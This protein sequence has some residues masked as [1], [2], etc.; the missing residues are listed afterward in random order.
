MEKAQK[1]SQPVTLFASPM[2][3]E[4]YSFLGFES[5]GNISV[6]VKGEDEKLS[7]AVMVY[8][9]H[10]CTHRSDL[11]SAPSAQHQ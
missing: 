6:Q 4:L 1:L 11:E 3:R 9:F 5:M 2:G 8:R 10:G 7:I